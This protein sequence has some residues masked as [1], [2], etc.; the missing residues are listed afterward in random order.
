MKPGGIQPLLERF[1]S[2]KEASLA[3]SE[4]KRCMI[5]SPWFPMASKDCHIRSGKAANTMVAATLRVQYSKIIALLRKLGLWLTLTP[6]K[7]RLGL[8]FS[9]FG[10]RESADR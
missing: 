2:S 7:K 4:F 8:L 9:R 6:T 1:A 10:L 5:D 3:S